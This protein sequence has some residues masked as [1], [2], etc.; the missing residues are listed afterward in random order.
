MDV[1]CL[2]FCLKSPSLSCA[3]P[4]DVGSHTS[5]MRAFL[6]LVISN[7]ICYKSS[8]VPLGRHIQ[9]IFSQLPFLFPLI[10]SVFMSFP[11]ILYY[12]FAVL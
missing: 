1:R 10:F 12:V 2:L 6:A 7:K 3:V 4:I 11:N 5:P 9:I 8:P